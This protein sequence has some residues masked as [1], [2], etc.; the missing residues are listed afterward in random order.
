[1]TIRLE[2]LV[3]EQFPDAIFDSADQSLGV[4]SFPEWDSLGTFNLL[5]LAEQ[6]YSVR[7]STAEMAELKTVAAIRKHLKSLGV[8]A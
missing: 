5:L 2:E 7:F 8:E 3:R 6:T 4:G 1:V